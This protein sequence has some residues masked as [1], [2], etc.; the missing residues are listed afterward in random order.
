[1]AKYFKE[2][3]VFDKPPVI[4]A[5]NAGCM[6]KAISF[7]KEMG[8][9]LASS[10]E[11]ESALAIFLESESGSE[12]EFLGDVE[13]K[14]VIIVDEI[15]NTAGSLPALCHKL[16]KSGANKIYLCAS[17]GQFSKRSHELI[18]LSVVEKVIISLASVHIYP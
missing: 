18:D 9:S 10:N 3:V 2:S 17:H 12:S 1:M 7:G 15:V 13:G 11:A 8:I 5:A 16:K 4:V 6:K 14:D